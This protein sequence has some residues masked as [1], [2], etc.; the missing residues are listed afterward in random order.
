MWHTHE[1]TGRG[2][3]GLTAHHNAISRYEN[4]LDLP[5]EVWN[6]PV[7]PGDSRNHLLAGAADFIGPARHPI[8][9]GR[10]HEK[11]RN[12]LAG[13]A[14]E[15]VVEESHAGRRG[16]LGGSGGDGGHLEEA[17][18]REAGDENSVHDRL[19]RLTEGAWRL[20]SARI[21]R[22]RDGRHQFRLFAVRDFCRAEVTV[23]GIIHPHAVVAARSPGSAAQIC[24]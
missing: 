19:H 13:R 23:L 17:G 21:D 12:I 1:L 6:E 20:R 10:S 16:L 15:G 18:E 24:T 9:C 5:P 4:L 14:G 7:A 2:A 8:R 11:V 22:S 3:T